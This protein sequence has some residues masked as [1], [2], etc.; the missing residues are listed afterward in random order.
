MKPVADGA[1][2]IR[3]G[4][5]VFENLFP[6]LTQF[7]FC[8]GFVG[9]PGVVGRLHIFSQQ[10]IHPPFILL[11]DCSEECLFIIGQVGDAVERLC[12][13]ASV[14]PDAGEFRVGRFDI[15]IDPRLTTF[16]D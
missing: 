7:L 1:H 14:D 6:T 16:I 13:P 15:G 2:L 8:F 5:P 11:D 3:P 12:D 9:R 10:V 4:F